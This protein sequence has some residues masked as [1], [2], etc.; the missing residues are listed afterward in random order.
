MFWCLNM[1]KIAILKQNYTLNLLI[2]SRI[3]NLCCFSV[4][5]NLNFLQKK[6]YTSTTIFNHFFKG[7]DDNQ[8]AQHMLDK[9]GLVQSTCSSGLTYKVILPMLLKMISLMR[10]WA[11]L[12]PNKILLLLYNLSTLC[13]Q[14]Y[15]HHN[16]LLP[17]QL[18]RCRHHYPGCFSS[19]GNTQLSYP[20]TPMGLGARRLHP[21]DIPTISR[22]RRIR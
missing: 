20:W 13:L 16:Q 18:G 9:F 21:H 3:A 10:W 22:H 15:A 7:M 19:S 1:A 5:R 2:D 17:G 4:G 14:V 6:F 11:R 12:F 8:I